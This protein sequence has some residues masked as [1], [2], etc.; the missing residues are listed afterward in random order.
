ML[1][2]QT[3]CWA[4]RAFELLSPAPALER[5]KDSRRRRRGG[6]S[7]STNAFTSH[8]SVSSGGWR[9]RDRDGREAPVGASGYKGDGMFGEFLPNSPIFTTIL[10]IIVRFSRN[11]DT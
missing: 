3:A 9:D 7:A 11:L 6:A 8:Q 5:F 1:G 4:G 10:P 2:F